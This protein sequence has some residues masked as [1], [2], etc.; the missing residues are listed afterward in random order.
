MAMILHCC[1]H[2][3]ALLFASPQVSSATAYLRAPIGANVVQWGETDR[4]DINTATIEEL[5]QLPGIGPVLASR[6]IEHR[7]KHGRFRRPQDIII[8]RGMSAGR[9]RRI[10]HLIRT[11]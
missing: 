6:I 3:C 7:R 8:V 9:F 4:L 10:A 2:V 11:S 1:I 5:V